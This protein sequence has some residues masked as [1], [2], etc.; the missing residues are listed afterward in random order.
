[1][2]VVAH[3][4]VRGIAQVAEGV[5]GKG[6]IQLIETLMVIAPPIE[7]QQVDHVVQADTVAFLRVARE[8]EVAHEARPVVRLIG[9][10]QYPPVQILAAGEQVQ[11]LHLTWGV[12]QLIAV[13]H[14]DT[15]DV[16]GQVAADIEGAYAIPCSGCLHLL[17]LAEGRGGQLQP[18]EGVGC[19]ACIGG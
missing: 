1:M 19:A 9:G 13:L 12:E 3:P 2:G 14:L 17:Q 16:A 7:E 6:L 5:A 15:Q 10:V 4:F 8:G 11:G 18:G